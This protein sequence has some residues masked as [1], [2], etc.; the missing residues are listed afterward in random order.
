MFV[1]NLHTRKEL[2]TESEDI[3]SIT[4]QTEANVII[5]SLYILKATP[6]RLDC[7][8]LRLGSC[9]YYYSQPPVPVT[10]IYSNNM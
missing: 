7:C 8:Y 2:F 3:K 5:F 4:T 10:N 1:E 6:L 9:Y